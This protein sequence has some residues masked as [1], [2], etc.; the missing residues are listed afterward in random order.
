MSVFVVFNNVI[1][2]PQFAQYRSPEITEY[3]PDVGIIKNRCELPKETGPCRA[4]I[5]MYYYNSEA[6]KCQEFSY[7]G[8]GGNENKFDTLDDCEDN[9]GSRARHQVN[10]L[11]SLLLSE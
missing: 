3:H 8:C 7:G 5:L 1:L 4:D 9:C 6:K 10:F 2:E 11:N